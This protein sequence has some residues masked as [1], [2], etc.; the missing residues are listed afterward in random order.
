MNKCMSL[1]KH[2]LDYED[3]LNDFL[4]KTG[5]VDKGTRGAHLDYNVP[6]NRGHWS[7]IMC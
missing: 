4:N 1:F 7:A 6:N 5:G 2:V 3:K